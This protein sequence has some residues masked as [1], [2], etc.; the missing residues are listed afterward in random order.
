ML[1]CRVNEFSVSIFECFLVGNIP[2][3]MPVSAD[4]HVCEFFG[5][6]KK[7]DGVYVY[8]NSLGSFFI[9]KN[10]TIV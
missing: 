9:L 6:K 7:D 2:V 5:F 3:K 8:G 10:W 4:S 1:Y